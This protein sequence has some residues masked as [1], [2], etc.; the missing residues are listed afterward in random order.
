MLRHGEIK[1]MWMRLFLG[2]FGCLFLSAAFSAQTIHEYHLENGLKL[3]VK[4]DRRAPVMIFSVWYKVGGSYEPNGITGISHVVEHMMFRGSK[5][6]PAG[7]LE[8]II[9]DNGGEQNAMTQNDQTVYYEIL[10]S[11]KLDIC[12]RLEADRMQNLMLEGSDF[13]KEIQVVMEERRMRYDDDPTAITYE[14]FMATAFLN[15]PYHHQTIGWMTDLQNMTVQDVRRWYHAWYA[16]NNAVIVIVGNVNPQDAL[17]VVQKYFD[18]IP[19]S[20]IKRLKP[21][22]EV[23]PLGPQR[24]EVHIPAKLPMVYMGYLAPS[25]T[26]PSA[27]WQPYALN[28]LSMLLGGGDSSRMM[29]DLVRGR[30]I[31]SSAQTSYDPF[32]LHEGQF[33]LIGIPAAGHN[34]AQ[35]EQAFTQQ[36]KQLQT[37]LV[38]PQELARVKAQ[39]IAQNVYDKDSLTNQ[40]LELGNMEAINVPWTVS[41]QYVDHINQVTAAQVQQVAKLYLTPARL[42]VGVLIPT[43][44]LK[45]EPKETHLPT[46]GLH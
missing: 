23:T 4:E 24:V 7:T 16:P 22:T 45:A 35:L 9:S 32:Q 6:Y 3:I 40:A 29:R 12:A 18:H 15:N 1:V 11:D 25:I 42:T 20:P 27:S 38:S 19:T 21:R 10:G 26:T 39:V 13:E 2:I 30:Q 34:L 36:I 37:Q 14:R 5:N 43:G 46:S 33:M 8:K 41:Q 31:A 17:A 44:E 28:V